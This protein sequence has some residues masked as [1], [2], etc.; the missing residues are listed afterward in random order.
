MATDGTDGDFIASTTVV[1]F[2]P[3]ETMQCLNVTILDDS[4][5]EDM[6]EDFEL[7]IDSVDPDEVETVDPA[8]TRISIVDDDGERAT[9]H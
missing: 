2:Q 8:T 1:M 5:D 7:V 3:G 9:I 6:E 4:L